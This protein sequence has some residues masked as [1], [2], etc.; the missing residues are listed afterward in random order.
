MRPA[1][2]VILLLA[3]LV[4]FGQTGCY[5]MRLER[6]KK[7]AC[8]RR[9]P[10][11]IRKMTCSPSMVPTYKQPAGYSQTYKDHLFENDPYRQSW[12]Q[13]PITVSSNQAMTVSEMP[14]DAHSVDDTMELSVPVPDDQLPSDT[15]E[16]S[17][18]SDIN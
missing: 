15:D 17:I 3:I 11:S 16:L 4:C 1:K 14:A 7:I 18:D 10:I 2:F 6:D 5:Y 8:L 9:S 13:G 12:E